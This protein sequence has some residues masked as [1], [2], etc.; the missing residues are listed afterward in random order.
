LRP[1]IQ[2]TP[3]PASAGKTAEVFVPVETFFGDS[4]GYFS[5]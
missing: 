4:E 3:L 1:R 5:S 2:A